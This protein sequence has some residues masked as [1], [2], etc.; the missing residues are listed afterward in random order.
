MARLNSFYLE[1]ER[2][3]PPYVLDGPEA[4]HLLKVLRG[5]PG[6]QIRLFD[7]QGRSGLFVIKETTKHQATLELVEDRRTSAPDGRL[8]LAIGWNK[9][10]RRAWILEKAVELQAQDIVF[11]QAVFSQGKVPA[12]PKDSWS[13]RFVAAAKQCGNV[14]LPRLATIPQGIPGLLELAEEHDNNIVLYE[15]EGEANR[16]FTP[17]P[18]EQKTLL[19]IGPEGGFS[20]LEVDALVQAGFQ[21]AGLGQS[22]LR[23]ETA[24]LLALGMVYI[25]RQR[26]YGLTPEFS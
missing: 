24:A 2:W 12:S 16:L 11:W 25:E 4:K 13:E 3:E 22:I 8:T 1:P 7:G 18:P 23:W 15:G 14:W 5:K 21:T 26:H 17:P 10:S 9:T 6:T 19:V 20:P